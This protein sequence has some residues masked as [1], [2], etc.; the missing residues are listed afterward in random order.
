MLDKIKVINT[1]DSSDYF[2]IPYEWLP[3]GT[4]G[5]TLNDLE[6]SAER[7]KKTG[8]LNRVRCAEIPA[9]TLD[10]DKR[11]TQGQ[12]Y[13][14]LR[15]LRKVEIYIRYFEKYENTFVTKKFYAQK[16]NPPY[17]EIPE[18]NNTNNIVYDKF[19]IDFAGYEDINS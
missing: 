6:A 15:L 4:Q 5:P 9:A 3:R 19:T 13:P 16:P 7:G 10:I 11:L 12:L 18:D 8:K 2:E 17:W 14:L 1:Q